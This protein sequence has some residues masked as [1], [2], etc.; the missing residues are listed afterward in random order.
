MWRRGAALALLLVLSDIHRVPSRAGTPHWVLVMG[1]S[2]G[3]GL[4]I[5][6][7]GSS[8]PL[9]LSG[10]CPGLSSGVTRTRSG[11]PESRGP[12]WQHQGL[13]GVSGVGEA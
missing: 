8:H 4:T 7:R 6:S 12:C 3:S 11:Q 13:A 5:S 1:A 9:S 10:G 2:A